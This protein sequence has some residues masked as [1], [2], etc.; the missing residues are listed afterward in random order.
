MHQ[1]AD[2]GT[3]EK[4]IIRFKSQPR[5]FTWDE[6]VRLFSILGFTLGNKGKTSGS[7]VIFSKGD[8]TY[9]AHKPH[10]EKFIKNYVMKQTLDY[11]IKNE[12]I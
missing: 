1:I 11:L 9:I 2:M 4:L 6:F 3:K 12:L 8:Y 5:D 10:P 7:R